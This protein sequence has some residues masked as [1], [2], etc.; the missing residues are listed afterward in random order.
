MKKVTIRFYNKNNLGDDLFVKLIADRY[1]DNFI[2]YATMSN[3]FFSNVKNLKVYRNNFVFYISKFVEKI[4]GRRNLLLGSLI[5]KSDLLLYV[6]GSIFIENNNLSIWRKEKSFYKNLSLPYYILGSNFGPAHTPEFTEIVK[7]IVAGAEDVCFR[8]EKS[9]EVFKDIS[10]ARVATD[11]AFTLKPE[12]YAASNKNTVVI[13][14][15]NADSRFSPDLAKQYRQKIAQLAEKFV[16]QQREVILMSFCHYEGDA[17]SAESIRDLMPESFA[18]QVKIY[19][20]DGDL[21]DALSVL[22]AANVIVGGR[23]HATILGLVLGKKVLPMAYSDKT[24]N[25][26][27]DIGFKGPVVDMRDMDS[28]NVERFD[29]SELMAN[30]VRA[31]V[32]I[33]EKQFEKLDKVLTRR[34]MT[35][36]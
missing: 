22:G 6:G 32:S 33:A 10:S 23:F 31:Q 2:T 9:Y 4:T 15:I 8:D 29:V 7:D 27:N 19:D 3:K 35:N 20:Y 25:I 12:A 17:A 16:N 14:V 5:T 28:F 30:D 24:I 11:I 1:S 36:E 21:E 13:S 34:E 26:L 18:K